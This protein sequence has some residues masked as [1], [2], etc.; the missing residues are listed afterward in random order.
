MG[1]RNALL[2]MGIVELKRGVFNQVEK[3]E[4]VQGP[5]VPNTGLKTR[6]YKYTAAYILA[7]ATE[8][9]KGEAPATFIFVCVF[10]NV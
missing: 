6:V 8:R 9:Y 2:Y 4:V 5:W 1:Q 3:L 10:M 7:P